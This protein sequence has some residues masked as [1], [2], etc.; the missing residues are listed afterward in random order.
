M[1]AATRAA[2]KRKVGKQYEDTFP[3]RTKARVKK[4]KKP[5]SLLKLPREIRDVIYS[6]VLSTENTEA[7]STLRPVTLE[8]V[9]EIEEAWQEA[10][11]LRRIADSMKDT[12]FKGLWNL[13]RHE[14]EEAAHQAE[15]HVEDCLEPVDMAIL[16]TSRR[17]YIEL[18]EYISTRIP[19]GFTVDRTTKFEERELRALKTAQRISIKFVF[20]PK[21]NTIEPQPCPWAQQLQE[22]IGQRT[23]IQFFHFEGTGTR[24]LRH[25][26]RSLSRK[27]ASTYER[28]WTAIKEV[29]EKLP[30]LKSSNGV[31]IKWQGYEK[32]AATQEGAVDEYREIVGRLECRE[33]LAES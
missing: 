22:T 1:P 11:R 31:T 20:E 4:S 26:Y 15:G 29:L 28:N 2:A 25:T 23:E 33:D 7:S 14:A 6:F 32:L 5:F 10:D 27:E 30:V 19:L 3:R 17:L 24:V 8:E 13:K 18:T 9:K 21:R 12:A 16:R